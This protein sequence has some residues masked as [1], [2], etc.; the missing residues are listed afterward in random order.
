[1][2][3]QVSACPGA[4]YQLSNTAVPGPIAIYGGRHPDGERQRRGPTR[5][6]RCTS[7]GHIFIF[8]LAPGGALPA[9]GTVWTMRSYIGHVNGGN[10]A[11][12]PEG[13]YSFTPAID[14]GRSRRSAPRSS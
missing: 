7:P 9:A 14:S 4:T 11:A 12:G 2:P 8:E 1:M 13:P 10:G 3:D 5:D 6:S